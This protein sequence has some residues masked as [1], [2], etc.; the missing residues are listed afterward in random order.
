MALVFL[1]FTDP[2]S[3][4]SA[5]RSSHRVSQKEI[6]PRDPKLDSKWELPTRLSQESGA[7]WHKEREKQITDE[8][9]FATEGVF[10]LD[11]HFGFPS[12]CFL[13]SLKGPGLCSVLTSRRILNSNMK[14]QQQVS[15]ST[16]QAHWEARS[17]H[18]AYVP[19]LSSC[20]MDEAKPNSKNKWRSRVFSPH[21]K[22][23][24]DH[25]L[26][27]FYKSFGLY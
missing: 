24:A 7:Q 15:E 17:V 11:E 19:C 27:F 20:L 22:V 9:T 5:S 14:A 12:G 1:I 8:K 2:E 18:T 6:Q 10:L 13:L 4:F 25:T 3:N 23:H 26:K 16:A 21:L